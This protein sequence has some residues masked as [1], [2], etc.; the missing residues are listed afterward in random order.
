MCR[1]AATSTSPRPTPAARA[2]W[3]T[4]GTAAGTTMVA[5][6]N[7][8]AGSSSPHYLTVVGSLLYFR[9]ND[10]RNGYELWVTDGTK[11]GTWMVADIWAG[12]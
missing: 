2:S 1:W 11:A 4:D 3:R 7:A 5:D 6:I 10:G 9:A 8:G 12:R